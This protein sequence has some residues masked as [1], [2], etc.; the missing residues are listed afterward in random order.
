MTAILSRR[1]RA[2]LKIDLR[3]LY[4]R[5]RH[6]RT[7]GCTPPF[8]RLHFGCGSRHVKEWTNVDVVGSPFDIDLAAPLP[9]LGAVFDAIVAQQVIEHLALESELLPLFRELARVARPGAEIWLSCPDM[10]K[11]CQGYV[12][13]RGVALK[14][15][16]ERR[17]DLNWRDGMPSSQMINV[18][19]HQGNE[20][21][22]LYDFDLLSWALTETGFTGVRQTTEKEFRERFPVFPLRDDDTCG[23]YVCAS[24]RRA[25][26]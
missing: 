12:S 9:W 7:R 4:A 11:V 3:R 18:L 24:C 1:T 19:F 21:K 10:A 17:W 22:N 23:L 25:E 2:S 13:D 15:D 16:R 26:L 20:H 6:Q 14:R 5:L 8:P